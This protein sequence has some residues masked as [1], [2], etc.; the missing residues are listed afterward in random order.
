MWKKLHIKISN[1]NLKIKFKKK[2]VFLENYISIFKKTKIIIFL[3]CCILMIFINNFVFIKKFNIK[4]IN[5]TIK[6]I[7]YLKPIRLQGNSSNPFIYLKGKYFK[8]SSFKYSFSFFYNIIKVEYSVGIFGENKKL[9]SPSDLPLYEDLHVYCYFGITK[10]NKHIVSLAN[11]YNN[12]YFN[13]IEFCKINERVKFGIQILKSQINQYFNLFHFNESKFDLNNYVFINNN[14]FSPFLINKNHEV[15]LKM[16]KNKNLKKEIY[17]LKQNY[18][19]YP[20]CNLKRNLFLKEGNWNFCNI[21]NHY[22]CFCYGQNCS[23]KISQ[24]CKLYFYEYIIDNN[25]Y[26][27]KKTDYLFIDFIFKEFGDDDTYP[28]FKEMGKDNS[29]HFITEKSEIYK[30]YCSNMTKCLKIIYMSRNLYKLFGDFLE[31]YL[32]LILKLKAVISA[33]ENSYFVLY[34]LYYNI[35]YI[36]YIAVGHGLCYFKFFLYRKHRTYGIKKNNKLLIPPSKILINLAKKYGWKEENLIKINLPRWDKYNL[37]DNYSSYLKNER[38]IK[39][40][41]ILIMFTWREIK[42]RKKIS[43]FYFKNI[44]DLITNKIL[45]TELKKRN[46]TLYFTIHRFLYF[47]NKRKFNKI[48]KESDFVF[49]NQKEI[50]ECLGKV[51]LV[52]TDFSSVIFDVMYRNK[53]FI[54]YVPDIDE[55]NIDKIY[56]KDYCNIFRTMKEDQFG[57]KNV[58]FNTNETLD[59]IIYYVK[60]NFTL[61]KELKKLYHN[62]IPKREKSIPKFIKYLKML[63]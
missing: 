59:K 58:F 49:I 24:V 22:F 38:R 23:Q 5:K 52:V 46:A 11:I 26:V 30:K 50:A 54:I 47:S 15:L 10:Q 14:I 13:C 33:I 34:K 62:F 37:K 57:F 44:F 17:K 39:N 19:K 12:E 45:S 60:N 9:I 53:A 1:N 36:T 41:S 55:P 21:Y 25:R 2:V 42:H 18:N 3:I 61:E 6:K 28:V 8:F 35:E 43:P 27:Y 4:T 40:N 20:L 63:T 56:S 31:K 48:Q 7:V 29:S 16:I 32:T 51:D